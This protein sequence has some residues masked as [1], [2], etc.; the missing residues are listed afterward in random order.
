MARA[1]ALFDMDRTLVKKDTAGLYARYQR[2]LGQ[3]TLRDVL[4]VSWWM[5]QYTFGVIDAPRVARQALDYFRGKEERELIASC[6]GWFRDYVLPHVQAAGRAA[7][8]RHRA[9]GDLV[10]IVTG[11]TRYAAQPLA[12]ELGIE[13]VVCT[14]LQLDGHGRFTGQ[15]I[16]PLCYGA[17]KL[18]RAKHLAE[19][20]GFE[21]GDATFYSDSITDLPLLE[22]V[23]HPRVVNP[24]ARLRRVA[25]QRGWTIE[26]W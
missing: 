2:D 10:A 18:E 26:E 3:A 8:E 13:E 25:R 15:P 21:L 20:Q 12:L 22:A 4:R 9:D 11:A 16:E 17:G 7:V 1:G 23:R 19:R 6:E 14:E 24:D 5:V